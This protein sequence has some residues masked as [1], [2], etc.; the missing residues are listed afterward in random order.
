MDVNIRVEYDS[1]PIRHIAVQCPRCQKWFY[2]NDI[3]KDHIHYSYEIGITGFQCPVCDT[4][5][6]GFGDHD[7]CIIT[8]SAYPEV[9]AGCVSKKV[10]WE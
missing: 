9:Y 10:T 2:G 7:K 6:G 8:E 3:A 1:T 5:F 4:E